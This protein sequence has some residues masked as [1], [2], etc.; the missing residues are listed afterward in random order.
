M[1]RCCFACLKIRPVH[2]IVHMQS[3]GQRLG[4]FGCAHILHGVAGDQAFT[5][6]P[7]VKTAPARQ[8]Q[9]YAT[10]TAPAAVHLRHPATNV[11]ALHLLQGHTSFIGVV[12][13]LLQIKGVQRMCALCQTLF[14]A[15]MV[16]VACDQIHVS[17]C[18]RSAFGFTRALLLCVFQ[19]K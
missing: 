13:E 16:E 18:V 15:H 7:N 10:A 14:I 19:R 1:G 4:R 11:R 17:L 12:L 6:Q 5:T 9:G 8:N 3:F 2:R